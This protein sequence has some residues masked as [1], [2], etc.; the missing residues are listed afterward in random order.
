MKTNKKYNKLSISFS[1]NSIDNYEKKIK[2]PKL[3]IN[4]SAL[5][6]L[7]NDYSSNELKLPSIKCCSN[8]DNSTMQIENQQSNKKTLNF[9]RFDN[10]IFENLQSKEPSLRKMF[11]NKFKSFSFDTDKSKINSSLN[12]NSLTPTIFLKNF[13]KFKLKKDLNFHNKLMSFNLEKINNSISQEKEEEEAN[14]R[15]DSYLKSIYEDQT[16]KPPKTGIFGPRNNIINIIRAEMERLKYDNIYKGVDKDLKEL[17]KDE[18]MDAQVKLKREPE[19]LVYNKKLQQ[20]L[21]LKKIE[22]YKYIS[23]MNKIRELNQISNVS[24]I[25]EDGNIM[26]ILAN[27]AYDSLI[28]N[29]DNIK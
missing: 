7:K 29:R 6:L 17:I 26:K 1:H 21:Y 24:I 3:S 15:N 13:K 2:T 14:K 18:I 16:K 9:N 28:K 8:S 25:E 12:V 22:K 5:N 20:P 23:S 10:P 19:A 4:K 27:D 11:S